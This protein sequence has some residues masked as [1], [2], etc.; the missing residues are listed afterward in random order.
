[1]AAL[2]KAVIHLLEK[3]LPARLFRAEWGALGEGKDP[4]KYMPFHRVEAKLP[5]AFLVCYAM[6]LVLVVVYARLAS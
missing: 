5:Q 1:V 4:Q 2:R 3:Q 6:V